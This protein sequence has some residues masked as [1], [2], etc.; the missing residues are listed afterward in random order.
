MFSYLQTFKLEPTQS[1][2][3]TQHRTTSCEIAVNTIT[4]TLHS[5]STLS[6]ARQCRM[7]W[8]LW[9]GSPA[10]CHRFHLIHMIIK[11][12]IDEFD[13]IMPC[14][15]LRPP[16]PSTPDS[17]LTLTGRPEAI[18]LLPSELRD[19]TWP[20]IFCQKLCKRC[21]T[22]YVKFLC[23]WPSGLAIISEKIIAPPSSG[24]T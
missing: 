14:A 17:T 2:F 11:W 12:W 6:D 5:D 9:S 24:K 16:P 23:D 8:E 13:W 20:D 10:T 18:H 21:P 15:A 4:H 22:S 1:Q 3:Q 7:L 19:L